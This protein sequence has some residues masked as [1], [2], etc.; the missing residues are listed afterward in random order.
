MLTPASRGQRRFL[1]VLGRI[2]KDGLREVTPPPR[3]AGL[4]SF[5]GDAERQL[6]PSR[7]S[8]ASIPQPAAKTSLGD[9][10]VAKH[11]GWKPRGAA[12]GFRQA[13]GGARSTRRRDMGS[14]AHPP[15]SNPRPSS[16]GEVI[17]Q[18]GAPT[19]HFKSF[20]QRGLPSRVQSIPHHR[21]ATASARKHRLKSTVEVPRDSG[22][23]MPRNSRI[24]TALK[25]FASSFSTLAS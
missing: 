9:G 10:A 24:V 11:A 1:V 3:P 21:I 19:L 18:I 12:F 14:A 5:S 25:I 8:M 13:W 17:L 16:R 6:A 22:G 7:R 2:R 23:S 4:G 15:D 20:F